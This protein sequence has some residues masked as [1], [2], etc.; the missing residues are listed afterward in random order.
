MFLG[1]TGENSGDTLKEM[2][3]GMV[4]FCA[5]GDVFAVLFSLV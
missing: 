3:C 5:V 2:W 1:L 4:P